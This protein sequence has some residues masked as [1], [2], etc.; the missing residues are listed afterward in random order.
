M[1]S[2]QKAQQFNSRLRA[3]KIKFTAVVTQLYS[4]FC[5]IAKVII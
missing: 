5:V 2:Q 1:L 4:R 3:L